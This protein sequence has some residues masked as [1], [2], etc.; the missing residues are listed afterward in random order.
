VATDRQAAKVCGNSE[1]VERGHRGREVLSR[2]RL[3]GPHCLDLGGF[4]VAGAPSG[5][6]DARD[7]S[8]HG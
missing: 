2:K 3:R 7:A 8:E 6:H 5:Y 4:G 1:A